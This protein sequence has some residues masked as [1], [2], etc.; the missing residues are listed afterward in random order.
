[1]W[2]KVIIFN[3][4]RQKDKL[5][6]TPTHTQAHAYECLPVCLYVQRMKNAQEKISP[7]INCWPQNGH[8]NRKIWCNTIKIQQCRTLRM[9]CYYTHICVVQFNVFSVQ[10]LCTYSTTTI[11][12]LSCDCLTI[13]LDLA[14]STEY[15]VH[16]TATLY[17]SSLHFAQDNR[18]QEN[19]H[20]ISERWKVYWLHGE[21]LK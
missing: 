16:L 14:L 13:L 6:D 4:H 19:G 12:I 2:K 9:K 8:H 10:I 17:R 15:L 5:T 1:M 3:T 21:A 7:K 18:H 20:Q 11:I